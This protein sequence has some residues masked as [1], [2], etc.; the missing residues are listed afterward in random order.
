VRILT[1]LR[2]GF[3]TVLRTQVMLGTFFMGDWEA[4]KASASSVPHPLGEI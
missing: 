2:G 1:T 4:Q 3:L